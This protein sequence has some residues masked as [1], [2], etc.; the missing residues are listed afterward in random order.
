MPGTHKTREESVAPVGVAEEA[1]ATLEAQVAGELAEARHSTEVGAAASS[2]TVAEK[3]M[4]EVEVMEGKL[5]DPVKLAKPSLESP[6][7][8]VLLN[9]MTSCMREPS[10]QKL[11]HIRSF[12]RELVETLVDSAATQ[13]S[14]VFWKQFDSAA[15]ALAPPAQPK[16]ELTENEVQAKLLRLTSSPRADLDEVR[17]LRRMLS[18]S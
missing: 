12:R 7:G 14:R 17:R 6:Q 18:T 8:A 15:N 16:W 10:A 9:S 11:A 1:N 4:L 5:Y 13:N 3:N 2:D